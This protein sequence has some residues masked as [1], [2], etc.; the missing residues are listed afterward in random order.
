MYT[1]Y[2]ITL[3][4]AQLSK[5]SSVTQNSAFSKYRCHRTGPLVQSLLYTSCLEPFYYLSPSFSSLQ[6]L[7]AGT[8]LYIAFFEVLEKEKLA[9]GGMTGVVGGLVVILGFAFMA[10]LQGISK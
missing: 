7:A 8:L 10:G 5:R 4:P 2:T 3:T 9:K 1:T 6:G